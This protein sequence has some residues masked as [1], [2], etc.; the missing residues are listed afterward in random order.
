MLFLVS[1]YILYMVES[2]RRSSAG[3]LEWLSGESLIMSVDEAGSR[4]TT[5]NQYAYIFTIHIY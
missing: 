3:V 2:Q 1:A 5:F 4:E